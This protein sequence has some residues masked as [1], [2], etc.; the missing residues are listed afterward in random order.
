MVTF[1]HGFSHLQLFRRVAAALPGMDSTEN[2]PPEDS[3]FICIPSN[4]F[5]DRSVLLYTQFIFRCFVRFL[6]NFVHIF[7]FSSKK[8]KKWSWKIRPTRQRIRKEAVH[9]EMFDLPLSYDFFL[10][11]LKT[12]KTL[13]NLLILIKAEPSTASR[14]V[15]LQ[16]S[17]AKFQYPLFHGLPSTVFSR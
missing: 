3:K 1:I 4:H 8:C 16:S 9:A 15:T 10:S 6:I 12:T 7:I 13:H 17:S 2:K 14:P 5:L 11:K